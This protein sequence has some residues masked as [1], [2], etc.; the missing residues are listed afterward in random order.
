MRSFLTCA[1]ANVAPA[2][3]TA[4]AAS[5]RQIGRYMEACPS[6]VE[7]KRWQLALGRETSRFPGDHAA[8]K[9]GIVAPSGAPRHQRGGARPVAGAAGEDH[10]PAL[11][12]RDRGRIELRH[13]QMKSAGIALE[14]K[15]VRLAHID[16][17]DRPVGEPAR[18]LLRGEVA[19]ILPPELTGHD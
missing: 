14:R 1:A 8:G 10:P 19:Y 7:I 13:G 16:E 2:A 4:V 11:R 9:M 12:I 15:L 6:A 18:H 17:Q 3:A 5:A